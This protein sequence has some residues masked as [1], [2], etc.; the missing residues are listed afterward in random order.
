MIKS[1]ANHFRHRSKFLFNIHSIW[2]STTSSRV[3]QFYVLFHLALSFCLIYL[4]SRY[5]RV[6]KWLVVFHMTIAAGLLASLI[7]ITGLPLLY[8]R[9][10]T[11]HPTPY[12]IAVV[13]AAWT[14]ALAFLYL[15]DFISY[16]LWDANINYLLVS[17]YLL[18]HNALGSSGL[19]LSYRI[20]LGL[21]VGLSLIFIV[22]LRLSKKLQ[23]GLEQFF[24]PGH[25]LSLFRDPRRTLQSCAA[26]VFLLLVY[27]SYIHTL[28][29]GI[30]AYDFLTYEPIMS[31]FNTK[32]LDTKRDALTTRLR[33]DEP[34]VRANYPRGQSFEKKNVIIIIVDALRADHTQVY[35]YQRPTT[36]FLKSLYE[37]GNLRKVAFA[38]ST[39]SE[40][41][42]GILSTL[43]SKTSR[44]LIP[45]DFKLPDLLHD[46]GYKTYF[47][48][49]GTHDW[50]EL[51]QSYGS[52]ITLYFDGSSSKK[53][54][55][56]TDDRLIFE[57]S[58][59]VPQ[60]DGTPAFFYSI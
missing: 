55:S 45:E 50:Y 26:L 35:G 33:I 34:Q 43:S 14:A 39:C 47:I 28:T 46:Q 27:G 37:T 4:F 2:R 23:T 13:Y 21:A 57:A 59:Q 5:I 52:G 18:R 10:R 32:L 51:K 12:L 29:R 42:C 31:F 9:L 60:F 11:W 17:Q 25:P 38:T 7:I 30:G 53:Y 44:G 58:E 49:S 24:L 54:S 6:S 22:H 41:N 3:L 16:R 56:M 15:M 48:L 20:Y 1:Q 8:G 40:S 19:S 36:P